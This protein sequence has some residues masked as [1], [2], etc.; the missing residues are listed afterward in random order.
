MLRCLAFSGVPVGH[1]L[2]LRLLKGADVYHPEYWFAKPHLG[3][4]CG[5]SSDPTG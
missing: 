1:R 2:S 4:R 5:P 3:K